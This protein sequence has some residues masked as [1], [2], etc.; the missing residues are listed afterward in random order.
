MI[1]RSYQ[2]K[3]RQF[4]GITFDVL[5][6]SARSMITKMHYKSKDHVEFHNHPNEQCG[7]IITGKMRTIVSMRLRILN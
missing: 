6:T 4:K 7:Y 3:S 5:A 1:V 2:A